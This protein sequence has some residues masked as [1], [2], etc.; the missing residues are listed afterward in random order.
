MAVASAF[1]L[2]TFCHP[3][4]LPFLGLLSGVTPHLKLLALVIPYQRN[5]KVIYGSGVSLGAFYI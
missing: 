5:P 4:L 1:P 2:F 3:F